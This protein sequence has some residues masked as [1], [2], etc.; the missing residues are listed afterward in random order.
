M[1]D[2]GNPIRIVNYDIIDKTN[3]CFFARYLEI[4]H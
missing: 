3:I 1:A 2:A 4:N